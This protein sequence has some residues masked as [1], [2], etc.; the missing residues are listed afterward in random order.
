[1]PSVEICLFKPISGWGLL[2]IRVAE[3]VLPF[4]PSFDVAAD[5]VLTFVPAVV[6][7]TFTEN[8]HELLA[9]KV[10]PDK[11]T[12]VEPATAVIVPPPQLPVKPFG[13]ATS[14]PP[15]ADRGESVNPTLDSELDRFGLVMVKDNVEVSPVK[16]EVGENDL[17]M[18]GGAITVRESVA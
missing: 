12:E 9:G 5:E 8:V 6:P 3:A 2:T 10:A 11:L 15:V 16:I 17:A 1:V 7:F 13:F 18:A 14:K 4:P